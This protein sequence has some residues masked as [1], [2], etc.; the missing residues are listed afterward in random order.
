MFFEL[1]V[2]EV[3]LI[4]FSN[5]LSLTNL[6]YIYNNKNLQLILKHLKTDKF[7]RYNYSDC[8]KSKF[9][10]FDL[11]AFLLDAYNITVN[12]ILYRFRFKSKSN[13]NKNNKID[14]ICV[15]LNY[16]LDHVSKSI[17]SIYKVQTTY[18]SI[19]VCSVNSNF[20]VCVSNS[21]QSKNESLV[22]DEIKINQTK[23]RMW[24]KFKFNV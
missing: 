23:L 15:A 5:A 13:A 24:L 19:F 8:L 11:I 14:K 16:N 3:E 9:I 6:I 17:E 20:D 18:K 1:F 22:F 12:R 4:S 2:C 7:V 21:F 10:I